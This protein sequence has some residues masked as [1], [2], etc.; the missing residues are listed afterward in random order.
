MADSGAS[1]GHRVEELEDEGDGFALDGL[2]GE[3]EVLE[4][5]H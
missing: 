5:G 1:E 4:G 2:A 3:G